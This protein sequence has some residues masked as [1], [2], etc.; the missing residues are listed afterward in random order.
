MSTEVYPFVKS[1]FR[2]A[3]M[4]TV[5]DREVGRRVSPKPQL[6]AVPVKRSRPAVFSRGD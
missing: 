2:A 4:I 6:E 5:C 3:L 1:D